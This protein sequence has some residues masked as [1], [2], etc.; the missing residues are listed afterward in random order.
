MPYVKILSDIDADTPT[1]VPYED[2]ETTPSQ[3][4]DIDDVTPE[5]ADSYVGAQVNLPIGGTT[6][7]GTVKRRA[8]DTNG[9]LQG[10]ADTN[11]ILDTRTY[12][13]EFSD[14]RTA[15][16]SA[17]AIAEHMFAQCDPAGNQY[18]TSFWTQSSI[19]RSMTP[20]SPTETDIFMSMAVATIGRPHVGSGCVYDGRMAPRHGNDWLT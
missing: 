8:W 5:V 1:F 7:E 11:P 6:S 15:E 19:T 20:P 13:V 16:F 9:N 18:L 2:E 14:G 12:E 4:P 3:L 17:N 10:K